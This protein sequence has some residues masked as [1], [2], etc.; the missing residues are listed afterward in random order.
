MKTF[1]FRTSLILLLASSF[2]LTA[3][4]SDKDLDYV[5]EDLQEC[6]RI[7]YT[8]PQFKEAFTNDDG[9]GCQPSDAPDDSENRTLNNLMSL[10]LSK[11]I[12]SPECEGEVLADFAF[13]D[14]E[15]SEPNFVR[16]NL[17]VVVSEFCIGEN[18]LTKGPSLSAPIAL[19]VEET[20]LSYI[21]RGHDL[22]SEGD[23][24]EERLRDVLTKKA[25]DLIIGGKQLERIELLEEKLRGQATLFFGMPMEVD[26]T[27][28]DTEDIEISDDAG[29]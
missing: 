1:F 7:E 5:S 9:C 23:N 26:A 8:C 22:V 11:Q 14:N 2:L 20:G 24:Y 6:S 12:I 4:G 25:A 19:S 29:V 13:V 28:E 27:T 17:W 15:Q 10:Y 3:C 21:I 18:G 16:Q